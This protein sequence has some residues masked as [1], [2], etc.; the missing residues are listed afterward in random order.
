MKI[1]M[2]AETYRIFDGHN[3]SLTKALKLH[4]GDLGSFLQRNDIGHIDLL[5]AREAGLVGGFFAI[6]APD[7][8]AGG[9]DDPEPVED[10]GNSYRFDLSPALNCSLAR[11]YT[12]DVISK[13]ERLIAES[14][15]RLCMVTDVPS[16]DQCID[17]GKLAIVLHLEGAEAVDADLG[18]LDDLYRRGVRSIGP[19]W[20]RPNRFGHGVPY[21]FPHSPDTGPGL[22]GAGKELVRALNRRGIVLDLSHL[23]E[24]GFWDAAALSTAPLVVSHA[25]AHALCPSTRN[26][27]DKQLEA[28]AESDGLVGVNFCVG[29][30]RPDGRPNTDTPLDVIIDHIDYI[31]ERIGVD[32]TAF[33]SDFDGASIPDSLRDVG[34]YPEILSLLAGRGYTRDDIR[35]ISFDNWRRVLTRTWKAGS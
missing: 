22:T 21:V 19:L 1:D 6:H 20:S 32:H 27:T 35:R 12:E 28:V 5:R 26:L 15:G 4:D 29:F 2:S 11:E 30:L 23:N 33:G 17:E 8:L 10:D 13:T 34:G 16:L 18:N 7:S 25:N 24:K 3:D 9:S 31:A 14:S